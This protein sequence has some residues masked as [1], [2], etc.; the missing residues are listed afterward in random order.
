MQ[1]RKREGTFIYVDV[2][3]SSSKLEFMEPGCFYVCS[4]QSSS[5]VLGEHKGPQKKHLS[6]PPKRDLC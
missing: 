3:S 4:R 5:S 6:S 1:S 2:Y